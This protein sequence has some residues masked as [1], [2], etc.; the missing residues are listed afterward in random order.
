M[1]LML[2]SYQIIRKEPGKGSFLIIHFIESDYN[3]YIISS[4]PIMVSVKL[5]I[6][7]SVV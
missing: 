1:I 2:N 7:C 5:A 4:K 6:G 3:F